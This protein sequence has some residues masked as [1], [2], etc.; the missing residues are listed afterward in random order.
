MKDNIKT[1]TAMEKELEKKYPHKIIAMYNGDVISVAD[2]YIDAM[3]AA[4][5]KGKAT[6][7]FIPRLGPSKDAVAIL[8]NKFVL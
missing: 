8:N 3:N 1:F 7:L 5:K 4:K 6:K 2:T